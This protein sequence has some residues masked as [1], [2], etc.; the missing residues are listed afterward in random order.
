MRIL[1]ADKFPSA[2]LGELKNLGHECHYQPTLQAD[3]LAGHISGFEVLVVRSTKV[4][5]NTIDAGDKLNLIIRAGAG[6][7]TIDKAHATAK[8]IAVCNVPGKNAVAVAELTIGLLVA[9]DRNIPDNV[10]ELRE[11]KW[12]KKA[13][14]AAQGLFGRSMGIV[15][16]GAIGMAVA[17]RA[18]AFGIKVHMIEKPGRSQE[19]LNKMRALDVVG[20][21]DLNEMAQKCDII[22]FHVPAS[23]STKHLVS[24]DFL[25]KLCDG[26]IVLN[27]S[28]AEIV[29]EEALLEAMNAK[30]IRA[31][32][33]VF[34]GEP[35]AQQADFDSKLS[36]HPNVYG[37]HHIGASTEQAQTAVAKGVVEIVEAMESGAILHRVN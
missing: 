25:S 5:S 27:T 4:N 10:I 1:F 33:D 8:G 20:V 7:N 29:D 24:R 26:A 18:H 2:Q 13:Y 21:A 11:G 32:L 15:G 9:V 30:S 16:A 17:E 31:G 28:R 23:D 36:K 19:T 6:T 22:S 12:N 3:D 35:G 37:T 34:Q 14:S